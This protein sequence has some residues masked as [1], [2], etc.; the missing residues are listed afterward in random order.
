MKKAL[1]L[2]LSVLMLIGAFSIMTSAAEKP[3]GVGDVLWNED[4]LAG[5]DLSSMFTVTNNAAA[6]S[7]NVTYENGALKF[8]G[9][10]GLD[11]YDL[12]GVSL[13]LNKTVKNYTIMA[14]VT[15]TGNVTTN[16]RFQLGVRPD[17]FAGAKNHDWYAGLMYNANAKDGV[18]NNIRLQASNNIADSGNNNAVISEETFFDDN[19]VPRP[20][21]YKITVTNNRPKIY[22]KIAD[23]D[24]K[25]VGSFR[26][27]CGKPDEENFLFFVVRTG[28]TVIVDN[29]VVYEGVETPEEGGNEGGGDGEVFVQTPVY[30]PSGTVI[31]NED[32]LKANTDKFS[33]TYQNGQSNGSAKTLWDEQKGR[34]VLEGDSSANAMYRYKPFPES[35]DYF[36]LTA[37]VYFVEN[38]YGENVLLQVGLR[39]PD[40]L[41]GQGNFIQIYVN[42]DKDDTKTKDKAQM[43][44]KGGADGNVVANPVDLGTEIDVGS[45]ITLKIVF[46][47]DIA[48]YYVNDQWLYSMKIQKIGS[49]Y[50]DLFFATR[51]NVK[52]EIDNLMIWSGVGEPS[53]DKTILNTEPCAAKDVPA[54]EDSTGGIGGSGTTGDDSVDE[55]D[56]YVAPSKDKEKTDTEAQTTAPAAEDTAA[57]E[58]GGCGS[59][60]AAPIMLVMCAVALPAVIKKRKEK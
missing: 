14:D 17:S 25:L 48:S 3:E 30:Y 5:K 7:S 24:W 41:W 12:K 8:V 9:K 33:I 42:Y 49:S 53:A 36:T 1:S 58:E 16:A 6:S 27:E 44:D 22:A 19:N 39:N 4:M 28:N 34:L 51:P 29:L 35:L 37:D 60:I 54:V 38:N 45:K 10:T 2:I 43:I 32:I 15:Y 18:I 11:A 57:V 13:G 55:D 31:L 50:G 21:S 52:W 56:D 46:D 40:M 23:G 20:V 47:E 59:A 26:G